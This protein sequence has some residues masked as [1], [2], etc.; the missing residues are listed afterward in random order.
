MKYKNRP[1]KNIKKS[2]NKCKIENIKDKIEKTHTP[3]R[4]R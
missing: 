2:T 1:L 4:D 3:R